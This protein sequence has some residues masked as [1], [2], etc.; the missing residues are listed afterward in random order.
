[1]AKRA[2]ATPLSVLAKTPVTPANHSRTDRDVSLTCTRSW[3]TVSR[4][5]RNVFTSFAATRSSFLSPVRRAARSVCDA[6]TSDPAA[7][8]PKSAS[9]L[10]HGTLITERRATTA[11]AGIVTMISAAPV[12]MILAVLLSIGLTVAT[13]VNAPQAARSTRGEKQVEGLSG[14]IGGLSAS[15][16]RIVEGQS[17]MRTELRG[18]LAKPRKEYV[19]DEDT[20]QRLQRMREL[21]KAFIPVQ[22]LPNPLF[23]QKLSDAEKVIPKPGGCLPKPK[24]P[25]PIYASYA[26]TGGEGRPAS[27]VKVN[28]ADLMA[29]RD[30]DVDAADIKPFNDITVGSGLEE[31]QTTMV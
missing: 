3:N 22:Y 31:N 16:G 8:I 2:S 11:H 9:N 23:M 4:A 27:H 20:V 17:Q 30:K 1:M 12:M 6:A 29:S 21:Q 24:L 5:E 10:D 25:S 18:V 28:V 15:V 14:E 26:A 13:V 19:V 7:L